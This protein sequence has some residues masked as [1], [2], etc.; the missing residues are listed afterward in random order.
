[1]TRCAEHAAAGPVSCTVAAQTAMPGL[2]GHHAA[3]V[4]HGRTTA[5][6]HSYM[7]SDQ[8]HHHLPKAAILIVCSEVKLH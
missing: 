7:A 5:A 1:M 4:L 2:H 3:A 8:N 6:Q